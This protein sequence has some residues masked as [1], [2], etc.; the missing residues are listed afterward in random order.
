MQLVTIQRA[1]VTDGADGVQVWCL[2]RVSRTQPRDK[3]QQPALRG[4]PITSLLLTLA[5][6]V[7]SPASRT[8]RHYA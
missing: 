6:A 8:V 5:G 2:R 7:N 3:P 4:N 1:D